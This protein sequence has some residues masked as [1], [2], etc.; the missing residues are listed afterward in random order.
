MSLQIAVGSG[1]RGSGG[2][3]RRR[4]RIGAL[5]HSGPGR[6]GRVP[7]PRVVQQLAA[8][9]VDRHWAVAA[10]GPAHA[11]LARATAV[12]AHGV[13]EAAEP[14]PPLDAAECA[15]AI[16]LAAAYDLAGRELASQLD[17]LEPDDSR[18]AREQLELAAS[19]SFLLYSALPTEGEPRELALRRLHL[20]ALAEVGSL[21][22]QWDRWRRT[23]PAPG[24]RDERSWDV[25]LVEHLADLWTE[26]LRREGGAEYPTAMEI[27]ARIREERP[28]REAELL[29]GLGRR[30]AERMRFYLF[31][32]YH[33]VDAATD[34]LMF[35][36]H[37]RPA[38]VGNA[39]SLHFGLAKEATSGDLV[40]DV[41]FSW[42]HL[43][44]LRVS[45]GHTQQLNLPGLTA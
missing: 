30:D 6:R 11:I 20:A 19:R 14:V 40:L 10:F 9:P 35:F 33:A 5:G 21:A 39:L 18:F 12:V 25:A 15:A 3:V 2:G 17:R 43:A 29:L 45:Q 38:N 27:I 16:D 44:A 42:M 37:H 26:L 1:P 31:A 34:L 23:H 24:G 36:L 32:L 7:N 13:A 8:R 28:T 22:P 4:A 41:L